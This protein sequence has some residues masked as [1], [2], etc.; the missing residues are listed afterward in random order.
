MRNKPCRI[1]KPFS[2]L[3]QRLER[4]YVTDE[5][6][7]KKQF[8]TLM[9]RNQEIDDMFMNLYA[10][11]TKGVLTE[12]RFLR[13][14]EALEQE[15]SSNKS[16]MQA[17]TDDL[18]VVSSAESDVRRFIKEIRAYAAITELNEII[19]NQLIDKIFIGSVEIV[20]GEKVQKVRVVYNFVGEICPG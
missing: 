1:Q 10:D 4:R 2:R 8:D 16:R 18:R 7:L 11:K 13:M 3:A 5:G 9:K 15:Q 14:T 20:D 12:Q 6:A 17:I 19:L